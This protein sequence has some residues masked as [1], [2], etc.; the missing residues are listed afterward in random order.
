MA[1]SSSRHLVN[2]YAPTA[3]P[4]PTPSSQATSTTC[5]DAADTLS[6]LLNRLPPNLSLPMRL[7]PRASTTAT[8]PTTT[9]SLP[10]LSNLSPATLS[11][12]FELGF[13]QLDTHP[14]LPQLAESA[15]SESDSIF[16]LSRDQKLRYFPREWPLGF[17]DEEEEDEAASF[18]LDGACSTTAEGAELGLASLRE[19]TRELEKVGL[20]VVESLACAMGF[21]NPFSKG[22]VGPTWLMWIS[23]SDKPGQFYPYVVGLQYQI[24]ARKYSLLSDSDTVVVEPKVGSVLVTLGDIAQVWSNGKIKKVR[25]KPTSISEEKP[26]KSHCIS[27]TL[28]LTLPLESTVSPL[29][30]PLKNPTKAADQNHPQT[31]ACKPENDETRLKRPHYDPQSAEKATS[32][33]NGD[34][35][36]EDH[37]VFNSFS[38]EDYAWRV[39]HERLM[40]KDPLDR[41][42]VMVN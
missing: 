39:Y 26:S 18:C 24:R 42:R 40:L 25:G 29:I 34:N 21:Q 7:S 5:S 1:A 10:T 6:Y 36:G 23:D 15:E 8:A 19:L 30:L 20:E 41:Y 2:A 28:L 32:N 4:P 12:A 22:R 27:M 13:F 14:I 3:A 16:H 33:E 11:S 9:K 38:F 17:D 31:E 35:D 37:K